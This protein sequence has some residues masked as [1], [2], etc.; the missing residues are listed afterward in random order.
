MTTF[1]SFPKT[2]KITAVLVLVLILAGNAAAQTQANIASLRPCRRVLVSIP[3]RELAVLEGE[4]VLRTF[5]I[6]VGAQVSPSPIG[7]FNIVSRVVNPTY[8]HPGVVIPAG[9]AN[10]IGPRWIGLNHKGYGIHGTNE[11]L[12]IGKAASHGCIRLRNQ[13]I[14]QLFAMLRVGDTVE[15]RAERDPEIAQIFGGSSTET[16]TVAQTQVSSLAGAG[17]GQ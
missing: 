12:S 7:Q 6:A 8:Y 5:S 13:E 14:K 2:A 10:P 17:G 15:I 11:P 4:K 3:D 9:K 16:S 1:S